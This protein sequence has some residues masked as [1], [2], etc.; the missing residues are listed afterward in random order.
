MKTHTNVCAW[1]L[2]YSNVTGNTNTPA[3]YHSLHKP[4]PKYVYYS[5]EPYHVEPE[6]RRKTQAEYLA[7]YRLPYSNAYSH[8]VDFLSR[9]CQPYNRRYSLHKPFQRPLLK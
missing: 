3:D 8:Q 9:R 5:L 4:V 7:F 1:D 2:Q 6:R